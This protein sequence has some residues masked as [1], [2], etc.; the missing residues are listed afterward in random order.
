V[1][2]ENVGAGH[3]VPTGDLHRHLV[4]RI[5]RAGA[6]ERLHETILGRRFEG[7][8]EGG[9]REV[10][11]ATLRPGERRTLTL[12]L[13]SVGPREGGPLRLELRLVYT[14]DEFPF[15]G[16]ELSVPTYRTIVARTLDDLP[17]CPAAKTISALERDRQR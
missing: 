16:R 3:N 7:T 11:D 13:A 2:L 4:L 8:P 9:K 6:P 5:W 14:I 15:R 17:A 10:A 1:T 12:P